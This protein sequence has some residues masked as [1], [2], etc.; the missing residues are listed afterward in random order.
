MTAQ[1]ALSESALTRPL[2]GTGATALRTLHPQRPR[3]HGAW[4]LRLLPRTMTGLVTCSCLLVALPM[5]VAVILSGATLQQQA[6]R[7]EKL[8]DEGLRIER[9]GAQLLKELENLE[10]GTLQYIALG[11]DELLTVL[12][13]RTTSIVAILDEIRGAGF[14]SSITRYADDMR[15]D[16]AGHDLIRMAQSADVEALGL[17]TQ[18]LRGHIKT[19]EVMVIAGR[20]SVDE[21]VRAQQE[22]MSESRRITRAFAIASIPLTALL[23]FLFSLAV[24]RPLRLLRAGISALG[25]SNYHSEISI[26]YPREMSRL[27]EKF[28][29]LRR[30]LA[31]LEADKNR[32]L[33]HVSH[34]LKTPLSSIR[35]GASLVMDGTLG[36]LNHAQSEVVQIVFDASIEL[37]Q[38]IR[39]LIAYAEWR[40][41]M[42]EA[43]SEWFDAA[44]LVREVLGAHRLSLTKRALNVDLETEPGLRLFGQRARLR[45]ALDNLISNAVKHAPPATT[46]EL[47]TS[48]VDNRCFMS[49]RD[50]GRGIPES[51]RERVLEP[52]VRG[53]EKEETAVRGTGVGL[54]IV[55]DTVNAHGGE[56]EI[57][58]AKPGARLAMVW[59]HP[60]LQD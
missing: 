15:A 26:A 54:S 16:L 24:T 25:T 35:E 42:R 49:V 28:D 46:I 3:R 47:V 20:D 8:L 21:R 60:P 14:A 11:D 36:T 59:P 19:A 41:G 58:D 51:E 53:T 45:I 57:Q 23:A 55:V 5:L 29:W 33:M 40:N 44:E 22:E 4:W 32:F 39:N 48:R 13:R 43:A 10:R 18:R 52:F 1:T 56:L 17:V 30:R 12:E 31:M 7:S 38:Q 2:L 27:G 9:L 50:H 34:E 6:Q 37:E